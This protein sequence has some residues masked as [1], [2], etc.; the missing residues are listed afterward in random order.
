ML[1][2]SEANSSTEGRHLLGRLDPSTARGYTG[3]VDQ[4]YAY[5]LRTLADELRAIAEQSPEQAMM[6]LGRLVDHVGEDGVLA[7]L[8]EAR[9]CAARLAVDRAG[10]QAKLARALGVSDMLVSRAV[11]DIR[12]HS[13][14]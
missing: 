9:K 7:R 10:S 11:R 14:P 6:T 8:R 1:L 4:P 12:R 5:D 3:G 13:N 2:Q